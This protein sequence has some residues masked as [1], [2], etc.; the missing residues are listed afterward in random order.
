MRGAG[1]AHERR[2]GGAGALRERRPRSTRARARAARELHANCEP[3]DGQ[4]RWRLM[5]S[6][7]RGLPYTRALDAAPYGR[8]RVWRAP[9]RP[10]RGGHHRAGVSTANLA[11]SGAPHSGRPTWAVPGTDLDAALRDYQSSPWLRECCTRRGPS[12]CL[13]AVVRWCGSMAIV[14]R[15]KHSDGSCS[16]HSALPLSAQCCA[17]TSA[18]A[19][20]ASCGISAH[21]PLQVTIL[22]V[23]RR[24]TT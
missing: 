24:T 19:T 1:V 13:L 22:G 3:E 14:A 21:G 12:P 11:M 6:I 16:L 17:M 23:V 15:A 10:A 9:W 18:V 4:R 8:H 20:C 5:F 2:L 7:S